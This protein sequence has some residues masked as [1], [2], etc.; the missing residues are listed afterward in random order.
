MKKF[1]VVLLGLS[2]MLVAQQTQVKRA[3]KV[4]EAFQPGEFLKYRIHYGFVDAGVAELR[5]HDY[6]NKQGKNTL[7]VTGQGRSVGMFKWFFDVRDHYE[8]Y[9]DTQSVL[10]V[11]FIR[12]IKEGDYRD[13]EHAVFNQDQQVVFPK[14]RPQDTLG[15]PFGCQDLLSAFYYA[16]TLDYDDLY[17]GKEFPVH[18]YLDEETFPINLKFV[19]REVLKTDVGKIPCLMFRPMLQEGRV[20]KDE[21]GMTIWV[22]DDKNHI[23]VMVESDIFV[24]SIKMDLVEYRNLKYPLNR[25]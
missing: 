20:F 1:L 21:E 4:E 6:V 11:E 19:G 5:V 13:A 7:K 24:G 22:T 8:S 9:I 18:V 12:D 15:I 25:L 3:L 2:G 10:P 14:D 23:P 16:R 17:L